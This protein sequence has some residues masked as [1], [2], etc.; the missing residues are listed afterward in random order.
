M[1]IHVALTHRTEYDYDRLIGL[2]PQVVRLR[3]AP[4]CRTPILSYSLGITPEEHFINW[5]QDP[6][7]NYLARLVFP[8][9]TREFKVVVDLVADMATINPFDFFVEE[10]AQSWP[11]DYDAALKEE[12]APYLK[13]GAPGPL[14]KDY[15]AGVK[16]Q[17]GTS[18]DFIWA[19]NLQL[20]KDI[21]YL[22]RMEPGVQTPEET[23]AKRSGSCRDS[24]WLLVHI[25]RQFGLAAR[26]VSGY[27]IQLKADQKSLDGPSGTE[28]DFTDLHAWAEVYLPGAGWIGLDPTSGLFAG[29]GHIPLA[30]TPSPQSAAPISGEH[31]EAEVTFGFDMQVQRIYESPRVTLPYSDDQW[32]AI[33]AAGHEVDRRLDEGDVRLSM[34]GE[35]TFVSIDD[36]DGAEWNTDAVGPTKRRYAENLI[37]RLRDRFA[38][39]GLLHYG[40]GKWYPGEQLPRWSFSVYWR[41]DGHPLW[42]NEAH[43]D[44]EIPLK[45]ATQEDA[46]RFVEVLAEQLGLPVDAAVPAYEDP[47]HFLLIEQKLPI[48]VEPE[49]NKLEDPQERDR[50]I[51]VFERGL[52]KPSGY[53]MPIQVWH[54]QARG[55]TWVTEKWNFRRRRLYLMPGDSPVGYR[56]PLSSTPYIVPS[57]Y[58][59]VIPTDPFAARASMPS[60]EVLLRSRRDAVT[61]L[62][63]PAP[64]VPLVPTEVLGSVRTALAIEPRDGHLCLFMP[65]LADAEDYAALAAAIEETAKITGQ[66]VH[67]EGYHPPHDPRLNVIKVTPDPG[68]IEVNIQPASN[69][70]EAVNITE[71]LYEEARLA[72]LGTE[73]FMIDGRHTGTGGGNHI[74]LG[75]KTP[76]DSPFLRRPDLLA[77]IITYWQN[78]PSLSYLFS[79]LF[80]GPTS[81]AP[82][83]DEARNDS[84]YEMEIAL[85]QIPDKDYGWIPSWLVDRVFRNLLIDSSGNTHRAEICIDKLYSPDSATGRLGLVEF[86]NFEMPPHAQMSLAQQLLLRALIAWFWEKPYK[87]KLIPWGTELHDRF[88]LP[89]FVWA[90]F[91]DVIADLKD[92]GLP[93]EAEW[94]APHFE[95]RFPLYGGVDYQGIEIELRQ[96]LEPWHVLGEEGAPGGTVRYVDSS[97]ER[98]Q[99]KVKGNLGNRY[100]VLC[101]GVTVPLRPTGTHGETV[102][103]VRFRAWWPSSCLQPTIAPHTPLVFDL[104]DSHA[105]RSVGG[106]RY[107][108]AHPGGRAHETFPVNALE[109]ETR[110]LARFELY[111]HTPGASQPHNPGPNPS[112]PHTLDLR[113]VGF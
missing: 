34:G 22:I 20:Q 98:L 21:A 94:F 72:R 100:Q 66:P 17:G 41:D 40:Q 18:L 5:Q 104:Y 49:D 91:K 111:G 12:L 32:K 103:G 106:C 46:G 112:F 7:G 35:P 10:S 79:G 14:L 24:G 108:V 92:A 29:E 71:I 65:P 39:G 26:F 88:M 82:R 59:H 77:S 4:H 63:P 25:M 13:A 89:D 68:V 38:P 62:T 37:R 23:L 58:P 45:P 44:H 19:L 81:Q 60:R 48:N 85:S 86:R 109:A 97:L 55:R 54:S 64:D 57:N 11:F 51:R 83:I 70:D 110:R 43:I 2:G 107:H 96:A 101:N 95:F 9:R 56:L 52:D 78:H 93:V 28:V 74:V 1:A 102:A 84:L 113:R 6:F 53:V 36:V 67:I 99:V 61:L 50:V 87:R 105:G 90:D 8:E 73:K 27:L 75:A 76:A 3:P 80:I 33:A 47:A 42:E 16:F 30:A 69:W 15:V 31:D